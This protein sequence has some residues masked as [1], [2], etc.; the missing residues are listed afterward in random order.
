VIKLYTLG[1]NATRGSHTVSNK[2]A[3]L[4]LFVFSAT[5]FLVSAV[6]YFIHII[7]PFI[8]LVFSG[9]SVFISAELPSRGSVSNGAQEGSW[10][11]CSFELTMARLAFL[12]FDSFH[13][14]AGAGRESIA[15]ELAPNFVSRAAE[16]F[17]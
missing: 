10:C 4:V 14:R 7:A 12:R 5:F 11:F 17:L 3:F 16:A 9:L 1:R 13:A 2:T 8:A 6:V 15:L